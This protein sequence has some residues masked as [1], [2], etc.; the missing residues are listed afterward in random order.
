MPQQVPQLAQALR[1]L[2][3]PQLGLRQV[4]LEPLLGQ[5]QVLWGLGLLR[6]QVLLQ[7]LQVF[8]QQL[9]EPLQVQGLAQ[10]GLEQALERLASA[11][12]A[13]RIT[14]TAWVTPGPGR[15]ASS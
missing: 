5:E 3:V 2:Q 14:E 13:A 11:T 4:L 7:E 6:E 10:L 12:G 1:G 15:A 8:L 9:L